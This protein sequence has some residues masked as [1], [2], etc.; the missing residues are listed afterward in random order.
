MSD[1]EIQYQVNTNIAPYAY[2]RTEEVTRF[3]QDTRTI[4]VKPAVLYQLG[5]KVQHQIQ[6]LEVNLLTPTTL[7]LGKE[8]YEQV[9]VNSY[10]Q[11]GKLFPDSFYNLKI[12]LD[13]TLDRSV[14]RVFCS[15]KEEM[16]QA[17]LI[18]ECLK[19]YRSI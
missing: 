11:S 14:A 15:V 8:F 7:V 5:N 10:N 13:P 12:I 19:L 17:D 2:H 6:Q 9:M 18:K 1:Y 16:I 3:H 4:Q